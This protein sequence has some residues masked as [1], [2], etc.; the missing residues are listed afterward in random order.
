MRSASRRDRAPSAPARRSRR[1]AAAAAPSPAPPTSAS[2]C[3]SRSCG[4]RAARAACR[5]RPRRRGPREITASPGTS[6][7]G[8]GP[9]RYSI[10]GISPRSV[11]RACSSR[12][13]SDGM[14]IADVKVIVVFQPVNQRPRV[15]IGHRPQP[16]HSSISHSRFRQS[17]FANRHSRHSPIAIRQSSIAQNRERPSLSSGSSP[18]ALILPR[19]SSTGLRRRPRSPSSADTPSTS[20]APTVS[21][22]CASFGP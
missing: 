13:H 20:S 2:S 12:A 15:E 16:N 6:A 22:T 5:S 3:P 1:S 7:Y 17:S 19:I 9:R 8:A 10:D 21:A 18:A 14:S 4:C 11:S